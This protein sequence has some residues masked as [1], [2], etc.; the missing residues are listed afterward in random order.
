MLDLNL[1]LD[2]LPLIAILR[3]LE[4]DNATDIGDILIKAGFRAIEVPL[5]SPSPLKSIKLLADAFGHEAIIGAGTVLQAKDV[6]AVAGAGGR[7]VVMP[8]ADTSLIRN[9]DHLGLFCIPG[10]ATPTEAFSAINAGADALKIFP[11]E[12]LPPKVVKSWRAVIPKSVRLIP[13]GGIS[14]DNITAYWEAGASGF[15]LG[16]AL[17]KPGMAH[18]AI[19]E[20]AEAFVDRFRRSQG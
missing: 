11:A 17:F 5:N 14:P 4:P 2:E 3:G 7:L 8:H 10:V 15:G 20:R 19:A 1:A 16:S 12:A 13:V 18:A 6:G 9:A